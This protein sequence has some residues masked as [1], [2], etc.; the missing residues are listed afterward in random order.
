MGTWQPAAAGPSAVVNDSLTTGLR[1][2]LW[3]DGT[4]QIERATVGGG[5][6][7]MLTRDEVRRLVEYLIDPAVGVRE[8]ASA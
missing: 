3:S 2:A 6:L 7:I 1:I 4:L 8:A 5:A